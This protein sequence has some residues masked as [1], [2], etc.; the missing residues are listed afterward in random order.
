MK[1]V[2]FALLLMFLFIIPV[3]ADDLACDAVTKAKIRDEA[4][5]IKVSYVPVNIEEYTV[6][7][8]RTSKNTTK[9]D[10]KIYNVTSSVYISISGKNAT[11]G[12]TYRFYNKDIGDDGAITLRV[13]IAD[14][15]IEL[16]LEVYTFEGNCNGELIKKISITIPRFNSYSQSEA[17]NGIQE[18]YLCQEYTTQ[19]INPT[20]F[21]KEV[22]EYRAKKDHPETAD[23]IINDNTAQHEIASA[24]KDYRKYIYIGV[25]I[26]L[27]LVS[28]YIIKNIIQK[29]KTEPQ[30]W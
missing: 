22:E 30:I 15:P 11:L 28:I 5:L 21:Y 12:S 9:M 2:L 26:A 10:V 19:E 24:K 8:E 18:F 25:A 13:P 27:I 6:D 7:G 3:K 23:I 20:T 14:S 16:E 29:K 1:K 4:S 17:C